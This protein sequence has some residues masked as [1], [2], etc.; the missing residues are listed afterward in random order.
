MRDS[1]LFRRRKSRYIWAR[2]GGERVSTRCTD[3]KAATLWADEQERKRA[4]PRYASAAEARLDDGI[5]GYLAEMRQRKSAAGTMSKETTLTGHLVNA[6]GEDFLLARIDAKRV[7]DL[8]AAREADGAKP[9]TV[10]MLLGTLRGVLKVAKHH[11]LWRGE[12]A[13]VMPIRYSKKHKPVKRSP[14]PEE[15]KTLLRHLR[16]DRAAHVAY[17]VAT[18]CRI[19]ESF[20]ARKGDHDAERAVVHVHGTKTDYADDEVPVTIVSRVWLEWAIANAPGKDV[21]FN[22]WGKYWRDIKAACV[23]A[24]IPKVTPNDLR[25]AFGTWHREAGA[26][27]PDVARMLR[28]GDDR[29][30]QTTYARVGGEQLG[31][32]IGRQL[33]AGKTGVLEQAADNDQNDPNEGP[34]AMQNTKKRSA[35]GKSRTCD[36]SFRKA[37]VNRRRQAGKQAWA[38]RRHRSGVPQ[39]TKCDVCGVISIAPRVFRIVGPEVR[40]VA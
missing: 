29:L 3:E 2:I 8:I 13:E 21:L 34:R 30:A 22:P 35:P 19:S 12:L 28:H 4:N 33:E 32:I 20:K 23:R 5:K 9:I 25:R 11:G 6:W 17:I 18:G 15:L 14:S 24:E 36:L 38:R 39:E 10:S 27:V 31:T 16:K 40:R 26:H 37:E 1:R 7:E